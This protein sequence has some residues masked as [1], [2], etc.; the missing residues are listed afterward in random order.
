MFWSPR[1]VSLQALDVVEPEPEIDHL[2]GACEPIAPRVALERPEDH[3]SGDVEVVQDE[4]R[5]AAAADV[6]DQAP[7]RGDA[8]ALG[9]DDHQVVAVGEVR[10]PEEGIEAFFLAEQDSAREASLPPAAAH[11]GSASAVVAPRSRAFGFVTSTGPIP[12]WIGRTG[13]CP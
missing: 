13:S 1:R 3:E 10:R 6:V 2:D 4:Q 5:Q 11:A 8:D 7:R 9:G 12:V